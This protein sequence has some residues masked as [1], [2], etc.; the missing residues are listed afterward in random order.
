MAPRL[1]AHHAARASGQAPPR[2]E[3]DESHEG[4]GAHG[5]DD[6]DGGHAEGTD[7]GAGHG[8]E[9]ALA[10]HGRR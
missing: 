1:A 4:G 5:Q 10:G 6:A 8:V 9:A 3:G 2:H 7:L